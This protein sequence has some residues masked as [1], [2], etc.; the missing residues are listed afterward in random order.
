MSMRSNRGLVAGVLRKMGPRRPH[1]IGGALS[2]KAGMA[3]P[4]LAGKR[5]WDHGTAPLRFKSVG[6]GGLS[7]VEGL[8]GSMDACAAR[9]IRWRML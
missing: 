5:M 2:R 6:G 7:R 1:L 4:C 8:V 3:R 9:P